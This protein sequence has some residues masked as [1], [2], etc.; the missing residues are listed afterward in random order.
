MAPSPNE[1]E[2]KEAN[3]EDRT[4]RLKC[5]TFV[6]PLW[7]YKLRFPDTIDPSSNF[8][9]CWLFLVA[10]SFLYNA[11][12]I[13]LRVSFVTAEEDNLMYWWAF[14]YLC[15]LI[16][17][18]DIVLMRV[19]I[20]FINNGLVERDRK[21]TRKNYMIS[22]G[23]RMDCASLI[24]LDLL[25]L[26]PAVNYS[27]LVRI[28]RVLKIHAFWE[29][30]ERMDTTVSN[31]YIVRVIRTLTYMLYLIHI[32]TCGY[33]AMS[34]YETLALN[35]WVFD[36]KGIAYVRC[37]YLATKTA[38]SIGNNPRP[39]NLSEY[40]FMTAYWLSGVF[41]FAMLIGQF[42]DLYQQAYATKENYRKTMDQTLSHLKS[43]S[44]PKDLQ[45]RVRTWFTYN[46]EHQKTLNEN[47]LLDA[48][49]TKMKAD[50]AI[51]V[52]FNTL[53]KVQLF[54][55]CD[56][57]LLFDLVLKLKP[58]LYLPMDYI[59]KKG[60]V[61]TEM[62]IVM[63]GIVEVVGGPNNSMVFATL[64]TGSVFGEISLLALAGGN[65]RTA[66]VRS[67]G[68]SQ[69]FILSKIDFEDAMNDYPEANK[70]LRK[71]AKWVDE[72]LIEL[73]S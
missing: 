35:E 14:D 73:Y 65:R 44:I 3:I 68:Y 61:G 57:N 64:Q 29:F 28:P 22:Q 21:E 40:S 7:L 11:S 58:V 18:I 51:H 20:R 62:Y 19:R 46:W 70:L 31:A 15:D 42:R 25:Y 36:G 13:P 41:V 17:I 72:H 33:Y 24:P 54:Q 2:L 32:E 56:K 1:I 16:Y 67:K 38:T 53:S 49:P 9:V 48:L 50:L 59:C 66:D 52:H 55:D 6:L 47:L 60:E 45:R 34:A 63:H 5:C 43:L 39:T 4:I 12:V 71:R 10:V 23:F 27:S 26:I 69:L 30:Y 37:M 8:Y